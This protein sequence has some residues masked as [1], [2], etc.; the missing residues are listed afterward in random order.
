MSAPNW[1]FY[2]KLKVASKI[3]EA[4]GD[5]WGANT[6]RALAD[7]WWTSNGKPS[8]AG[9]EYYSRELLNKAFDQARAPLIVAANKYP[10]YANAILG[11]VPQNPYSKKKH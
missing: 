6:C 5:Y 3:A 2:Q 11:M 4:K 8:N 1:E 10:E 7:D 9:H